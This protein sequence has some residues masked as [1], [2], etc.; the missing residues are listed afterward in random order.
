MVEKNISE[1]RI[2]LETISKVES[3]LKLAVLT[4][5]L[6]TCTKFKHKQLQA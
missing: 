2:Y 3:K 1:L 6:N 5:Y 4:H